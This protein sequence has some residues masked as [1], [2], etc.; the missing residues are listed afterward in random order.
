MALYFTEV[1]EGYMTALIHT[2]ECYP[3]QR[4]FFIAQILPTYMMQTLEC[5]VLANSHESAICIH[6][7]VTYLR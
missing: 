2:L 5:V 1:K 3:F 6:H 4:T 7:A